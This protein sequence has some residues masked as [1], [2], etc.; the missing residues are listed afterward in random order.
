L[1]GTNV[2]SE[3]R[4]RRVGR[5]AA[6]PVAV[7]RIKIEINCR[8]A[9]RDAFEAHRDVEGRKTTRSSIFVA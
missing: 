4:A 8:Y 3:K 1:I 2:P 7:G 5:R 6:G 9:L